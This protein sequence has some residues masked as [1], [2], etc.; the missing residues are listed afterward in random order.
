MV[1]AQVDQDQSEP[2]HAQVRQ[3]PEGRLRADLPG[4]GQPETAAVHRAGA[5]RDRDLEHV[6]VPLRSQE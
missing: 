2:G 1:L 5:L 3:V 4:P 6:L